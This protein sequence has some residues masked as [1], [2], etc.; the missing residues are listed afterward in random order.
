MARRVGKLRLSPNEEA[1]LLREER[2][3]RRKLRIQQVREQ[4]KNFALQTRQNVEQRRRREVELLGE[5]L[6]QQ[7]E[8]QR[9]EKLRTLEMLFEKSLQMVGQGHRMAK[10]NEPDVAAIAQKEAQN[11]AKAEERFREALKELKSQKLKDHETQKRTINARKKALQLERE[12]ATKVA[13]LPPPTPTPILQALNNNEK[14]HLV[15]KSDISDF[16]SSRYHVPAATVD[17]GT[18]AKQTDAH[19]GAEQAMKRLEVFQRDG[20][21]KRAE[22]ME[23]ARLRGIKALKK[24]HLALDRDRL[25]VELEHM[26]QA[27]MLKRRQQAFQMP[28]QIFQPP[29]RRQEIK[30][31]FQRDMEFAFENMYI[32]EKKIK[33]DRVGQLV[34]EPIPVTS[35]STQDPELDVS[36]DE[37]V[38]PE[39]EEPQVQAGS[40]SAVNGETVRPTSRQALKNLLNRIRTQRSDP[41]QDGGVP[42]AQSLVTVASRVPGRDSQL[43]MEKVEV[44]GQHGVSKKDAGAKATLESQTTIITGSLGSQPLTSSTDR[45]IPEGNQEALSSK[46]LEVEAEQKKR[47]LQLEREKQ[48]QIALLQ[49]LEEQK[50]QLE[51]LLLESQQAEEHPNVSTTSEISL[52]QAGVPQPSVADFTRG[53]E[54]LTPEH[55][56]KIRECQ[57]RLLEQNR[58]HQQSIDEA[59][60]RLEDYQRTLQTRHNVARAPLPQFPSASAGPPIPP[61]LPLSSVSLVSSSRERINS[62]RSQVRD[63]SGP[64]QQNGIGGR[65]VTTE[66]L[67]LKMATRKPFSPNTVSREPIAQG[68]VTRKFVPSQS[69]TTEPKAPVVVTIES[70][71]SRSVSRG[72]VPS[73]SVSRGSIPSR[74]VSR[75]SIPS[76][77]VSRGS[78]PSHPV[79]KGSVPA[80]SASSESVH[81]QLVPTEPVPHGV[82]TKELLPSWSV[83]REPTPSPSV[84]R[85]PGPSRPLTRLPGPT[86]S[87]AREP[88]P[89]R[90]TAREPG[91][92]RSVAREQI[93]PVM[94]TKELLPFQSTSR[95]PSPSQM[96]TSKPIPSQSLSRR[97]IPSP[98]VTSPSSPRSRIGNAVPFNMVTRESLNPRPRDAGF[99]PPVTKEVLSPQ[100]VI[101]ESL[102]PKTG[103]RE[104]HPSKA[105]GSLSL[106]LS[107]IQTVTEDSVSLSPSLQ[108]DHFDSLEEL[109]QQQRESLELLREQK[110]TLQALL[111]VDAQTP[112]QVSAPEDGGQMRSELLSS[113]LKVIEKSNGGSLPQPGSLQAEEGSNLEL[114]SSSQTA[115]FHTRAARPPVTR[116]RLGAMMREQH[117]L[118]AIQEVETPLETSQAGPEGVF[119]LPQ[120]TADWSYDWSGQSLPNSTV[121]SSRK[122]SPA[123]GRENGTRPSPESSRRSSGSQPSTKSGRE[124]NN[125]IRA[126][127]S[128]ALPVDTSPSG[129]SSQLSAHGYGDPEWRSTSLSTGSFISTDPEACQRNTPRPGSGQAHSEALASRFSDGYAQRI[130]D[131][132]AKELNGSLTAV[133]RSADT[134][135]SVSDALGSS[136]SELS[137]HQISG[138]PEGVTPLSEASLTSDLIRPVPA[139]ISICEDQESFRALMAQTADQ[140]SCLQASMMGQLAAEWDSVHFGVTEQSSPGLTR[141]DPHAGTA[142]SW[143]G[144][145]PEESS[146]RPLQGELDLSSFQDSGNS[147]GR[148]CASFGTPPE[149]TARPLSPPDSTSVPALNPDPPSPMVLSFHPLPAEVTHNQSA[150]TSALGSSAGRLSTGELGA[151]T[152]SDTPSSDTPSSGEQSVERFRAEDGGCP[153]ATC[154]RIA[155][156]QALH[157]SQSDTCDYSWSA[158]SL[159]PEVEVDE[160]HGVDVPIPV[161]SAERTLEEC[162]SPRKDFIEEA[163]SEAG[164]TKGILQQSQITLVSLTDTTPRDSMVSEA[165]W[166]EDE[167]EERK[168]VLDE[169]DV[170]RCQWQESQI[171]TTEKHSMVLKQNQS[172]PHA[173]TLLELTWGS[174]PHG[175]FE[176]K[177]RALQER[178]TRRAEEVKAKGAKA[179]TVKVGTK[180][181]E[182]P[183]PTQRDA[184]LD[185]P[186]LA[187]STLSKAQ[188]PLPA[189]IRLNDQNQEKR[190]KQEMHKRTQRLYDQLEEVKQQ[191]AVRSRQEACANNRLKAKAFHMKTLQKLRTKQAQH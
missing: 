180:C 157:L 171:T 68:A 152:N 38:A 130:I 174:Q 46:I 77:S 100:T 184:Q 81:S 93:P 167:D 50:A 92:P 13:H 112:D 183:A 3:R 159:L 23:A 115:S 21:R 122:S 27:D 129:E 146:M 182:R 65:S 9:S 161:P 124:A 1:Q 79:S 126:S 166:G 116:V 118:S 15:K 44:A 125:L 75:G 160:E 147:G 16:A 102:T 56:R 42:A 11:H 66:S 37:T 109:R 111:R 26:Q 186:K 90:S 128:R 63:V 170:Y 105:V 106:P 87:V 22:Q 64:S 145:R 58:I 45:P 178:S 73:R 12:R 70:V 168:E 103:R 127:A 29:Q 176:Q 31:E 110:E 61:S 179:R 136:L 85:E 14:S 82:V 98:V 43:I 123:V 107:P 134:N 139:Q 53:Q 108:E 104:F 7:W 19:D 113:L 10:E 172:P 34:P 190:S 150:A 121:S 57:E 142:E 117:E 60:R 148:T 67:P 137:L 51:Q 95:E 153:T 96:A 2:E 5:E 162:L 89:L 28:P 156:P 47:E 54:R 55:N 169:L 132:Y 138:R 133:G 163:L 144:G 141:P 69:G 49:E 187:K 25:L 41:N 173:G 140:S 76:R 8:H 17:R 188:K 74:S 151:S 191:K 71:P 83:A 99:P 155:S 91:P 30:E 36:L 6:R 189:T 181:E 131:R 154:G 52:N 97:S 164:S 40:H 24:E 32:K 78:V 119:A 84:G 149:A 80:R 88:G 18:E 72:S 143:L 48:Q 20:E 135:R 4:H 59:R 101:R 177:R 33:G 39:Q 165:M 120:H 175:V 35:T 86:L 185:E 114:P 94:V 158:F 62:P